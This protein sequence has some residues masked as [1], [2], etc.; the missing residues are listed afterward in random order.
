MKQMVAMVT[1]IGPRCKC[2]G[3][4]FRSAVTDKKTQLDVAKRRDVFKDNR[5]RAHVPPS[6]AANAYGSNTSLM[7]QKNPQTKFCRL[8]RATRADLARRGGSL[9]ILHSC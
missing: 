2:G 9:N 1:L 7:T 3:N 6:A 5:T 4:V 8:F